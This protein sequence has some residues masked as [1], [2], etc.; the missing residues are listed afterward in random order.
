MEE[1]YKCA[2][3]VDLMLKRLNKENGNQEILLMLRKNTGYNDGMY[4]LPGGHVDEGEDLINAMIREAEEEL[5]IKLRYEDLKIEHLLHNYKGDRLKFI[6]S[7]ERYEGIPQIGESEKCERIEWFDI[8]NLPQ[9]IDKRASK[10]LQ[11]IKN[12]IKYDNSDFI[13]L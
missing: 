13:N 8:N 6:I 11:E 4:E 12:G 5:K 2:I 9:N 10:V 7:T 3:V 1:R